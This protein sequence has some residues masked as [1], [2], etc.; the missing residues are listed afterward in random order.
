MALDCYVGDAR[1]RAQGSLRGLVEDA[2]DLAAV[3]V[4]FSGYRALAVARIV[5]CE[6]ACSRVGAAVSSDGTSCA[7]GGAA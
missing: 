5:P 6:A 3:D 1:Q 2:F 7:S 4:K